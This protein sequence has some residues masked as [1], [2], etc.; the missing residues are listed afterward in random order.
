MTFSKTQAPLDQLLGV[1]ISRGAIAVIRQRLSAAVEQPKA[2]ALQA[3]RQQPVVYMGTP[4]KG[5]SLA[6]QLV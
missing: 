2:E 3:A 4:E 6:V 1:Q 5:K